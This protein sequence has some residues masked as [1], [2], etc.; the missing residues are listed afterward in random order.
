LKRNIGVADIVFAQNFLFH[1][2]P[3]MSAKAFNNI[4]TL[5]DRRAAFFIDGMDIGLRSRL[6][7]KN[8][9]VPLEYRI[10]EIHNE[11]RRVRASGWPYQYWGLEPFTSTRKDWQRRY[12]T[13]FLRG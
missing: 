5:L 12:S 10:E 13:I 6:T 8:N 2:K 1:L 9:L 11:A 7:R 3:S 4:A